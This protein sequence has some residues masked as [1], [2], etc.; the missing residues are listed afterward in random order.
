MAGLQRWAPSRLLDHQVSWTMPGGSAAKPMASDSAACICSQ[1]TQ[2]LLGS[3][4]YRGTRLTTR[5]LMGSGQ[6]KAGLARCFCVSR[7]QGE[8]GS[9]GQNAQTTCTGKGKHLR[10][11]AHAMAGGELGKCASRS[12]SLGLLHV[13]D[14]YPRQLAGRALEGPWPGAEDSFADL[15]GG[16]TVCIR[17]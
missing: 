3:C 11:R 5:L 8:P 6:W 12:P 7:L 10:W 15:F 13:H 2:D 16:A 9:E 4:P 17:S 1:P 14:V